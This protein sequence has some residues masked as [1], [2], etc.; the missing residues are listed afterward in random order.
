M[1]GLKHFIQEIKACMYGGS[2]CMNVYACLV[3]GGRG[4]VFY[5]CSLLQQTT[6]TGKSPKEE[7]ARVDHEL[8]KI[9]A[10][11]GMLLI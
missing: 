5:V 9:R 2:V 11:F 10:T 6:I 8:S 3:Y 4:K 7:E 1:K